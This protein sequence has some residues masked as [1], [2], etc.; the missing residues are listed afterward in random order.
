[1]IVS[2]LLTPETLAPN[3]KT[4]GMQGFKGLTTVLLV[5]LETIG[6]VKSSVLGRKITKSFLTNRMA[7]VPYAVQAPPKGGNQER[8]GKLKTFSWTTLMKQE[9]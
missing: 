1:M 9:R 5:L 7:N 6:S 4:V 8:A 3:V 2:L